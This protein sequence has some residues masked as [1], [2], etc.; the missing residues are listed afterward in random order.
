M[1][2]RFSQGD[3]WWYHFPSTTSFQ[4]R[5]YLDHRETV[6]HSHPYTQAGAPLRFR[7]TFSPTTPFT[8]PS[9]KLSCGSVGLISGAHRFPRSA[10]SL[11]ASLHLRTLR[12]MRGRSL[13]QHRSPLG[14]QPARAARGDPRVSQRTPSAHPAHEA[15]SP[16]G[17]AVVPPF[18]Q[19]DSGVRGPRGPAH[20]LFARPAGLPHLAC[21]VATSPGQLQIRLRDFT[22]KDTGLKS[23][24]TGRSSEFRMTSPAPV[25]PLEVRSGVLKSDSPDYSR[26]M[27]SWSIDGED[28]KKPQETHSQK[29]PAERNTRET[30]ATARP[31]LPLLGMNETSTLCYRNVRVAGRGG[32][33]L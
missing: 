32:A 28:G 15:A 23:K 22:F 27:R 25:S 21:S 16:E 13:P 20:F 17:G 24:D 2:S 12:K 5:R 30:H 33:P 19:V 26:I 11:R 6:T 10:F 7:G 4:Q 8:P 18:L 3:D 29:G 14:V 31:T 1:G 9:S